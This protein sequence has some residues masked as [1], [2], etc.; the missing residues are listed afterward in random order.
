MMAVSN[1]KMPQLS[2][3]PYCPYSKDFY[4]IIIFLVTNR[5]CCYCVLISSKLNFTQ[6]LN[7]TA[8]IVSLLLRG[9]VSE[10]SHVCHVI[11]FSCLFSCAVS[12]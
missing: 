11:Q 7:D 10:G 5:L 6:L 9:C 3:F 12:I 8:M 1:Y 2:R 4:Y